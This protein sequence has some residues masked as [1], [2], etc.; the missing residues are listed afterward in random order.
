MYSYFIGV[1]KCTSMMSKTTLKI[2]TTNQILSNFQHFQREK[3]PSRTEDDFSDAPTDQ[4]AEAS[5]DDSDRL[6]DDLSS[7]ASV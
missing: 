1:Y 6:T 5:S 3:R 4:S 7:D 2:L